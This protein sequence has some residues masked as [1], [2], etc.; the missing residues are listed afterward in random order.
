MYRSR[1]KHDAQRRR[2]SLKVCFDALLEVLPG[3]ESIATDAKDDYGESDVESCDGME[4][5]EDGVVFLNGDE[6]VRA[7]LK[8]NSAA[9][10]AAAAKKAGEGAIAVMSASAEEE[11]KVPSRVE[12]L[13]MTVDYIHDL[14]S[15]TESLDRA[16]QILWGELLSIQDSSL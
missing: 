6:Y 7:K 15:K 13:G 10:E 2:E 5:K 3:E 4:L 14:K 8:R 9:A 16:V 11:A 12:I 1:K